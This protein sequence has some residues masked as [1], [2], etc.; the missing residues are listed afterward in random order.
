MKVSLDRS[1]LKRVFEYLA[2]TIAILLLLGL[3]QYAKELVD[4]FNPQSNGIRLDG[5]QAMISSVCRNSD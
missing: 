5:L 1:F 2:I 3:Q 4:R